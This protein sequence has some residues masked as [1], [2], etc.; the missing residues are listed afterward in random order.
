MKI[1]ITDA[2]IFIDLFY[3]EL[4]NCLFEVGCEIYTTRNVMLELE[5]HHVEELEK[6]VSENK[7]NIVEL[8]DSDKLNMSKLRL[9]R[10]LSET[11][12]S[13]IAVAERL[14]AIVVSGD[15]LVRKTCHINK[16]EIHGVLWCLDQFVIHAQIDKPRA[17]DYLKKLMNY[18]KRLPYEDCKRYIQDKWNGTLN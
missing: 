12:I 9:N 18:N 3:L 8:T 17:C 1:A 6:H 5:D 15:N 4:D 10:G 11:D 14:K 2:N 7:L 16:I 13:V